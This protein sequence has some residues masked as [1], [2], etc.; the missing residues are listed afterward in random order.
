MDG[1]WRSPPCVR[2]ARSKG[3]GRASSQ[4][5]AEKRRLRTNSPRPTL[6]QPVRRQLRESRAPAPDPSCPIVRRM[7]SRH[8]RGGCSRNGQLLRRAAHCRK[9]ASRDPRRLAA[10]TPLDA[11]PRAPR[12]SRVSLRMPLRGWLADPRIHIRR[13][14]ALRDQRVRIRASRRP[15]SARLAGS[16]EVSRS[17][18]LSHKPCRAVHL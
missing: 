6:R 12:G 4:R 14:S 13:G 15:R 7:G 1:P 8:A 9:T 10:D 2:P 3:R 18:P 11:P 17:S 16:L 5:T